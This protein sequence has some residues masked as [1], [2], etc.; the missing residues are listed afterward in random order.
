MALRVSTLTFVLGLACAAMAAD[1]PDL[2]IAPYLQNVTQTGITV[3]WETTRPVAGTVEFGQKGKFN[4]KV[5]EE[6]PVKIHEVRLTGLKP[7]ETY[8]YRV[9][10][11]EEVLQSASFTTAPPPGTREWRLVVY[12]DNRSNPDTHAGNV[13]QIMEFKPGIVL[14]S[15]DLVAQGTI[16]EQWKT[17]YFD[18][19]RG[20]SEY[21]PVYT[22]LGNHERNA[23]HYY[24]YISVPEENAESYYSFDY[25]NA[26][27]ISLNTNTKD[28]PFERGEAQTEWLI[29]DL[30]AHRDAEWKIVFFHN[31]LFRCHPTRGITSQRWVWQPIFDEYG[32]DLVVCGHDHYY[33]R[34]YAVGNYSG[35]PRRGVTHLIS[36]GGGAGT[37]PVVPKIHAASRRR[38][39]HV[40]LL[41]VMGDRMVGRAVD[42]D[43]NI[44]DAFVLDRQTTNSPEEFISYGIYELE[45]DLG[46]VIRGMPVVRTGEVEAKIDTVLQVPNPFRA[47]VRMALSWNGTNGWRATP[48]QESW[49]IQ[50]GDPIR[51]PLRAHGRV[52][53]LYPAPTATLRFAAPDGEKA[54]RNDEVTFY[55][56]K[57]WSERVLKVADVPA[58]PTVD[59]DQSDEAWKRAPGV[60][61]F[62]DVQGHGR[63]IRG[64]SARLVRSGGV[65]YV[66]ARVDAPAGIAKSGYEGRDNQRAPRNDH[67]RVHL[68][69]GEDAYTFLVTARGTELDA[70]GTDREWN[71]TFKAAA[72]EVGGGW[73]MEM[74]IPL[75]E[76][77]MSGL[78]LRINLT[79]RDATANTESEL[80]PTFGRSGLD[81]RVPMYQGDWE[82]VERFA[83]L[84]LK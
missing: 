34:T 37:Y 31:P 61:D 32:V 12:G 5:T 28:A 48:L 59:G 47:P 2:Y 21:V 13:K 42:I 46:N 40:T 77:G 76:L 68:G 78:P 15:G 60:E 16:Y 27:I 29:R 74:A 72:A 35:E 66:A 44:F 52:E 71:S 51:I 22:C 4:R 33:Q 53:E 30:E 56:L 41:D 65:L 8:G 25:A 83:V 6:T 38:V 3:M 19:M 75:Q 82:A 24:N 63:P 69:A 84:K 49:L 39:H 54:F 26:H 57:L 45:R 17:Q 73:Q 64:V 58:A 62:V 50:P 23:V 1:P 81:H 79:R 10:Y 67:F 11:G 55:P 80:S 18:P 20:L 14:N 9:R 43:G 7:G 70:K 36:G